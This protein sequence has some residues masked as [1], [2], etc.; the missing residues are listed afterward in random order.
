MP[1]ATEALPD[2]LLMSTEQGILM[3]TAFDLFYSME[4]WIAGTRVSILNSPYMDVL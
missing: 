2:A 1:E 4:I 3:P